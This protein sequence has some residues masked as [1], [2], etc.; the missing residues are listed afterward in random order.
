MSTIESDSTGI[1][2]EQTK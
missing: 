1:V 2:H